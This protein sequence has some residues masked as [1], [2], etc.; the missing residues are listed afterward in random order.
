MMTAESSRSR[1][2]CT[3]PYQQNLYNYQCIMLDSALHYL[4]D[5]RAQIVG[6]MQC[7][8]PSAGSINVHFNPNACL[9]KFL[10]SIL[11]EPEWPAFCCSCRYSRYYLQL[12]RG[13]DAPPHVRVSLA[14]RE[15]EEVGSTAGSGTATAKS[16]Y[17]RYSARVGGAGGLLYLIP[18]LITNNNCECN[19]QYFLAMWL[20]HISDQ[21]CN[22]T[23]NKKRG[24]YYEPLLLYFLLF[25]VSLLQDS[26]RCCKNIRVKRKI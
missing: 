26:K 17:P 18:L 8:Q 1:D 15:E 16:S 21:Y 3:F 22:F 23:K 2:F 20:L 9:Q 25:C 10:I 13:C 4:C 6:F 5:H 19:L 7:Q 12:Y 11:S 24:T 14:Q